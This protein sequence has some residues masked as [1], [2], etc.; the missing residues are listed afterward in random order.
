MTLGHTYIKDYSF[1][2]EDP[3]AKCPESMRVSTATVEFAKPQGKAKCVATKT[4][5]ALKP[6]KADY[7]VRQ[8]VDLVCHPGE[9]LFKVKSVGQQLSD[10]GWHCPERYYS[11]IPGASKFNRECTCS[12]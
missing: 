5:Y 6:Q 7:C 2:W 11:N 4:L 12:V 3:W 9:V 1:D 10:A 8:T